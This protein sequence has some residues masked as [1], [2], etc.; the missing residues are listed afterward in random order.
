MSVPAG[1][2]K[3]TLTFS[4]PKNLSLPSPRIAP[5][6]WSLFSSGEICGARSFFTGG[7]AAGGLE[8]CAKSRLASIPMVPG[9][10][11]ARHLLCYTR[12]GKEHALT[13]FFEP[14]EKN[15]FIMA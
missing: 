6:S 5:R 8:A 13:P 11:G 2:G 3:G 9:S 14:L 15:P 10:H 4:M 1:P 12:A 7:A